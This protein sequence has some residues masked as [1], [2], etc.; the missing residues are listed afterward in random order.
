MT[1]NLEDKVDNLADVVKGHGQLITL[2]DILRK[3]EIISDEEAR[4]IIKMEPFPQ[5]L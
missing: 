3:R 1:N 4:E 2:V 5:L